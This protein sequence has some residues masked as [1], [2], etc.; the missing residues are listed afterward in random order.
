M[1]CDICGFKDGH[2]PECPL[3]TIRKELFSEEEE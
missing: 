2:H 3:V 1:I